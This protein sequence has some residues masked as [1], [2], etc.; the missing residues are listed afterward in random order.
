VHALHGVLGALMQPLSHAALAEQHFSTTFTCGIVQEHC[1]WSARL[2]QHWPGR[3]CQRRTRPS[4]P[5]MQSPRP[6]VSVLSSWLHA[7]SDVSVV[8][9]GGCCAG[10]L[11]YVHTYLLASHVLPV[12]A[13]DST[14]GDGQPA[15]A[16]PRAKASSYDGSDSSDT[17]INF[18]A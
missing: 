16:R 17:H 5:G 6:S 9:C 14:R 3:H 1:R 18:F 12:N 11:C 4:A 2:A 15:E 10:T 13:A 8:K 7:W